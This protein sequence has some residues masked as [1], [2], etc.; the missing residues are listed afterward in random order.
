MI[1]PN[2]DFLGKKGSN[3]F[4]GYKGDVEIKSLRIKIPK[5]N[6][7]AKYFDKSK[8]MHF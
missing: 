8:Y 6:G 5:M 2:K 4:L 7:H 1:I 3:Y